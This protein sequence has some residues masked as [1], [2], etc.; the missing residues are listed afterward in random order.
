MIWAE[1]QRGMVATM[2]T[3]D[4][5]ELPEALAP[6]RS[7]QSPT[8]HEGLDVEDRSQLPSRANSRQQKAVRRPPVQHAI[9]PSRLGKTMLMTKRAL[10][11]QSGSNRP[12]SRGASSFRSASPFS[13]MQM[14]P[15][16]QQGNLAGD[17][18]G[19]WSYSART[20]LRSPEDKRGDASEAAGRVGQRVAT[21]SPIPLPP[22]R[23]PSSPR[24]RSWHGANN[25]A[26]VKP[27]T[28]GRSPPPFASPS[29][30][31]SRPGKRLSPKIAKT[32]FE[33][34]SD[35]SKSP[36]SPASPAPL[37]RLADQDA[38]QDKPQDETFE[39]VPQAVEMWPSAKA[40]RSAAAEK[41]DQRMS[42]STPDGA[43]KIFKALA[44][45]AESRTE[46]GGSPNMV[47]RGKS[48]LAATLE[49]LSAPHTMERLK[50]AVTT[51]G[52]ARP[53]PGHGGSARTEGA[54][55]DAAVPKMLTATIKRVV[56]GDHDADGE[57]ERRIPA[58]K[59]TT[60]LMDDL[61][62]G[63]RELSGGEREKITAVFRDMSKTAGGPPPDRP[64]EKAEKAGKDGKEGKQEAAD[65]MRDEKRNFVIPWSEVTKRLKGRLSGAHIQ[66]LGNYFGLR[67]RAGPAS[68]VRLAIYMERVGL[69]VTA[70]PEKRLKIAFGLLDVG[71]D[72]VIG[73]RD[74]FAALAS[75]RADDGD[76]NGSKDVVFSTPGPYGIDFAADSDT[77]AFEVVAVVAAS[78]ADNQGVQ[79]GSRLAAV[80][81]LSVDKLSPAEVK[82]L[83]DMPARPLS[84]TLTCKNADSEQNFGGVEGMFEM[85]DFNKL[86]RA[87]S[88]NKVTTRVKVNIISA[89]NLRNADARGGGKSDPYCQIEVLK[90][91]HTRWQT[92]TMDNCLDPEWKEERE[93]ADWIVGETFRFTVRDKDLGRNDEILGA[94]NL[95]SNKLVEKGYFEGD[96]TLYEVL[97]NGILGAKTTSSL[98]VKLT[99]CGE[100]GIGLMDFKEVFSHGEPTFLVPL[101]EALTGVVR[102]MGRDLSLEQ[103]PVKITV[104]IFNATGLRPVDI[105]GKSDPYCTCEISGRPKTKVSTKTK[106]GTL[107][108]EWKET[109]ALADYYPGEP[110]RFAVFD[111]D[112]G[113]SAFADDL[114]GQ[115]VLSSVQFWPYGFEGTVELED[116]GTNQ[117]G[118]PFKPTVKLKVITPTEIRSKIREGQKERDG[119]PLSAQAILHDAAI[120]RFEAE[121]KDTKSRMP[122]ISDADI[123]WHARVFEA[124]ADEDTK[125]ISRSRFVASSD[126]LFGL[127]VGPMAG[128]FFDLVAKNNQPA[129][130]IWSNCVNKK[131]VTD[132]SWNIHAIPLVVF[133]E[134]PRPAYREEVKF[135]LKEPRYMA[136]YNRLKIIAAG[137]SIGLIQSRDR[138]DAIAGDEGQMVTVIDLVP[139]SDNS[140]IVTAVGDLTFRVS[141]AWMPRGYNGVQVG[142]ADVQQVKVFDWVRLI[143][144][145]RGSDWDTKLE[146][147][148]LAFNLY[149]LDGDGFLSV[150]DA[151]G[152]SREVDRLTQMFPTMF[153]EDENKQ[154]PNLKPICEEMRWL[155]GLV[156]NTTDGTGVSTSNLDVHRFKQ[157]RPEP[158]LGQELEK[159][160]N[161]LAY[162]MERK[163][164]HAAEASVDI[165]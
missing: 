136:F 4:M 107:E 147:I 109:F 139:Q 23:G 9:T 66:R 22:M 39:A 56:C 19:W 3:P 146:R 115:Y 63:S 97:P 80:N 133:K 36:P 49:R 57:G 84:L 31:P 120:S 54:G 104:K 94:A 43:A 14:R 18:T 44:Q 144:R 59:Q 82:V 8:G 64:G 106:N 73:R 90:K 41:T 160:L 21:A 67:G 135:T 99:L 87:L 132:E 26:S 12:A 93:I 162:D 69:L 143:E 72:S 20:R 105:G 7:V 134:R 38:E 89:K 149:D 55:P 156:A 108:P 13:S 2:Y 76:V 10:E 85:S 6:R 15:Q 125:L 86:L 95:Q 158:E 78:P 114:L 138:Q 119:G 77:S 145:Y 100:G 141:R 50:V 126:K 51:T 46:A 30:P 110:L 47:N 142:I 161:I 127:P 71:G 5:I 81:G 52:P 124:L 62:A 111:S 48:K 159:R 117:K 27:G 79:I 128:K 25:V 154:S 83:L 118:E 113:K 60:Y 11:D 122:H 88:S 140:I 137:G 35:G 129:G 130:A 28:P 131:F 153:D 150:Q 112:P 102:K 68:K 101:Q 148:E 75:T 91:E 164:R 92:K 163:T 40:A 116:G 45:A 151:V 34:A 157:L 70:T 32:A 103:D 17:D 58:D 42:A 74:V 24:R 121:L 37:A 53:G 29:P 61:F 98:K 16:S 1:L 123:A 152:L 65:D 165:A 155:Y 33:E 96:L